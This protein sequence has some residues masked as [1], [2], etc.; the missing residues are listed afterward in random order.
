MS[1][2]VNILMT[3]GGAP[4]A[5]GILKCL[6]K[7]DSFKVTLAD[8]NSEA[9]GKYLGHDFEAIP[10]A[11]APLFSETLLELCKEKKIDVI[12]PL[13]TKELIPFAAHQQE[14]DAAGI[15]CLVSP[16]ASL[17][18]ANNKSRLYEFMQ[19]RGIPVPEFRVIET[20]EQ[21]QEAINQLGYP[22]KPVCFKPSVSNGSRG[23]RIISEQMNKLDLLFNQKP[24]ALF[25]SATDAIRILS[26]GKFPELLVS[27]YLPGEEYSVDCLADHGKTVLV[28]PRLRK[29]IINGI[30]IEGEFVREETII[31]YCSRVIK[32]LQLHGNIGIQVKRAVA[33][34]FLML[35]IN[36]RVQGSIATCLGAGINLPA[37]AI[38]QELGLPISSKE[39]KVNWGTKFSRYWEEVFY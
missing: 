29:K 15:K 7:E 10:V 18:I 8:A 34:Q 3:G 2:T 16:A 30:S 19:W 23:F 14:F 12:L 33:G 35:E 26:S 32:E 13:V 38:K 1:S 5:A 39:L 4:G 9:I 36:P 6:Q 11:I 20:V 37:L 17:E 27:E 21:F 31:A 22:G 24:S 28:V 25:I